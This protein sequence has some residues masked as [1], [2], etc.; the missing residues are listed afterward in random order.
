MVH[1]QRHCGAR[2]RADATHAA[3]MHQSSIVEQI[4]L[5]RI[6]GNGKIK[7]RNG[8]GVIA[9]SHIHQRTVEQ[10]GHAAGEN[11]AEPNRNQR[12]YQRRE[13]VSRETRRST[14]SR[15]RTAITAEK[16]AYALSNCLSSTYATPRHN[17]LCTGM[18]DEN[19]ERQKQPRSRN[20]SV[21]RVVRAPSPLQASKT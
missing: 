21:P 1:E 2:N 10:G 17:R 16:S 19:S 20:A 3:A 18:V 5:R 9:H 4:R 11:P 15:G 8:S 6:D 12:W 13:G 7:V 14:H